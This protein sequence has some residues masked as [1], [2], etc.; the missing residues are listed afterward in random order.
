MLVR[1]SIT[2]TSFEPEL[3]TY[4]KVPFGV[5]ATRQGFVPTPTVARTALVA[6]WITETLLEFKF[7]T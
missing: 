1:V 2:D 5:M 7:A 3:V 4:A 6:V